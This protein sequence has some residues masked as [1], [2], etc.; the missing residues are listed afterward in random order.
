[1]A[2]GGS[3]SNS[4][5][6][7]ATCCAWPGLYRGRPRDQAN[8]RLHSGTPLILDARELRMSE[9]RR[10]AINGTQEGTQQ[11]MT[12][13]R[14][15]REL[16]RR[17]GAGPHRAA[18]LAGRDEPRSR[19]R[20]RELLGPVG[21]R[22]RETGVIDDVVQVAPA[23]RARG[24]DQASGGPRGQRENH[25]RG[26]DRRPPGEREPPPAHRAREPRDPLRRADQGHERAGERFHNVGHSSGER[27]EALL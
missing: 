1:M 14:A 4:C 9:G 20:G 19:G 7:A 26:L 5:R 23:R 17:V 27:P 11:D 8:T 18:P 6:T 12:G 25:C 22:D 24:H 21:E 10:V 2:S 15:V 13:R 16:E 3:L